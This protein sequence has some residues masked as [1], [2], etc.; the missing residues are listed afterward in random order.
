MDKSEIMDQ[1]MLGS[2]MENISIQKAYIEQKKAELQESI[3]NGEIVDENDIDEFMQDAIT[4][5]AY[6]LKESDL[7]PSTTLNLKVALSSIVQGT[8][9]EDVVVA[10]PVRYAE[11]EFAKDFPIHCYAEDFKT[12]VSAGSL[13][14]DFYNNTD[15]SET[16]REDSIIPCHED[17]PLDE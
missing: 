5:L 11:L 3:E 12:D 9:F 2:E 14:S 16:Y 1:D 10:I 13:A 15:F 17:T 4:N 8:E 7:S 6:E